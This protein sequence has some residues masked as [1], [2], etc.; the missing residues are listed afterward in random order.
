MTATDPMPEALEARIRALS[1]WSDPGEIAAL[2]GGITNVNAVVEDAGRKYVVR[3]GEDIPEHLVMRWNERHI[4][5][6][7]AAA[8]V[9]PPLRHFEPG[10]MVFD[11]VESV[12][13]EEA[14]LHD[15]QTLAE[16]VALVGRVHRE[17]TKQITGPV[18]TFWVFHVIRT[19]AAFLKANGSTHAPRLDALL[20]QAEMLEDGVGPVQLVLGHNDLLP[21]NILRGADRLWLVDW[22]YGGFNSPLFDLGGLASNA[23]LPEEAEVGMLAAYFGAPPDAALMRSYRAMKCASLLREATWSMVSEISSDIEFDYAAYTEENMTRYEAA[24][25]DWSRG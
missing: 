13:L 3:L 10:V 21:A 8:G 16:A 22:E 14:D 18:L 2:G 5:E 11:H 23:G 7:A 17:V 24:L 1:F 12:A 25:A 6:A 20:A 4:A 19:Y 9:S 15:A